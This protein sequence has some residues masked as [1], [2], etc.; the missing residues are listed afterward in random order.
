MIGNTVAYSSKQL[1]ISAPQNYCTNSVG[2]FPEKVD[3]TRFPQCSVYLVLG[4]D[5]DLGK[6]NLKFYETIEWEES[7]KVW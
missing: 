3:H 2:K 7:D 4:Q 1:F 6:I 5:D